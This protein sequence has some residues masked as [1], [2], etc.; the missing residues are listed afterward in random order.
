MPDI[1]LNTS[2]T[3]LQSWEGDGIIIPILWV[4]KLRLERLNKQPKVIWLVQWCSWNLNLGF[5]TRQCPFSA[6]H[7]NISFSYLTPFCDLRDF[8]LIIGLHSLLG[9]CFVFFFNYWFFFDHVEFLLLHA[10]FSSCSIGGFLSSFGAW[11]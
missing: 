2:N 4:W 3:L 6:G 1:V 8:F 10:D 11:A 5:R 7:N 9:C